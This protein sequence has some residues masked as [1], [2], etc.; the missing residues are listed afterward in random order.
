MNGMWRHPFAGRRFASGERLS[1]RAAIQAGAVSLLGLGMNHVA[2]LR[3]AEAEA[4]QST[5]ATS[6][7]SRP[8]LHCGWDPA[9]TR[10][11]T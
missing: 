7:V 2:A 3:E 1:R 6:A 4:G 8:R 10:R 11:I 5:G 9:P